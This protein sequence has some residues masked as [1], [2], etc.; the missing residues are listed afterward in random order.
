MADT[1]DTKK[2]GFDTVPVWKTVRSEC[3]SSKALGKRK[4]EGDKR[5]VGASAG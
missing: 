2:H 4:S 3:R 1:E 5:D